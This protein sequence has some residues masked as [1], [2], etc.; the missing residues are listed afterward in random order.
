MKVTITNWTDSDIHLV[1]SLDGSRGMFRFPHCYFEVTCPDGAMADRS[2]RSCGYTN[3]LREEDFV[4][5]PPEGEFD[6]YQPIDDQGFFS[7]HELSADTFRAAGTYRIRFFYSS[8]SSDIAEWRGGR[9]ATNKT[10]AAV[11]KQVPKVAV[12]SNEIQVT[13]VAPGSWR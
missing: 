8:V 12:K 9:L 1:G 13:V 6:P 5:V 10:I 11:F 2:A 7:A 4:R 3:R